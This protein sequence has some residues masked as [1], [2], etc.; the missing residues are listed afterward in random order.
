MKNLRFLIVT[1]LTFGLAP[2]ALAERPASKPT[3]PA[4]S[5]SAVTAPARTTVTANPAVR[6]A[7]AGDVPEMT[8]LKGSQIQLQG[9]Q[10]RAYRNTK[11][12]RDFLVFTGPDF[13]LAGVESGIEILIRVPATLKKDKLPDL[14]DA[15]GTLTDFEPRPD[16]DDEGLRWMPVVTVDF[17]K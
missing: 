5:K 9:K 6:A 7:R 2:V 17:L 16:S 11:A 1:L 12:Y 15:T 3:N 8:R 10:L 4:V 14:I 13:K